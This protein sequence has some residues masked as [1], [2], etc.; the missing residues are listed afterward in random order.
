MQIMLA[1]QLS[2][3]PFTQHVLIAGM[4]TPD[5]RMRYQR[6]FIVGNWRRQPHRKVEYILQQFDVN[7]DGVIDRS[8]FVAFSQFVLAMN[9]LEEQQ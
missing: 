9:F 1:V 6:P 4:F 2:A 3:C 5:G 7:S 8:E